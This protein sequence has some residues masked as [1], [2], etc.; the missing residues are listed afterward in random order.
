MEAF[1]MAMYENK[2]NIVVDENFIMLEKRLRRRQMERA[3]VYS[4]ADAMEQE[5]SGARAYAIAPEAYGDSK[6][7]GGIS[8]YQNGA[9]GKVKY[10]TT[11][12]Y[13]AYFERCHDTFGAMNLDTLAPAVEKTED[14]PKV[15]IN[16][17]QVEEIRR[18]T[19]KKS[20]SSKRTTKKT[21]SNAADPAARKTKIESG[22]LDAF[23]SKLASVKGQ[24]IASVAAFAIC[25]TVAIGGIVAHDPGATKDGA[26]DRVR[27]VEP[28]SVEPMDNSEEEAH[29]NLLSTLE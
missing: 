26:L 23:F 13:V 4:N 27:M 8:S 7:I 2:P 15:L 20:A 21:A 22:K 12:D 16:R 18:A 9:D 14:S 17:K 5:R 29:G 25:C 10:M 3:A 28:A 1:E 24:A 19:A 11:E 6:F